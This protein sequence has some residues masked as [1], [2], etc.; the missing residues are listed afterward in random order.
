MRHMISA[1]L[2]IF[3]LLAPAAAVTGAPDVEADAVLL[4]ERETGT[5]LYEKNAHA[6]REPASV[7]KIMTMLLVMEAIEDG[8]LTKETMVP[9]SAHAAGMGGS[10]VYLKEGEQMSVHDML[11]AVAVASGNDAAVALGEAIAGSES[12]FVAM[13]NERAAELGMQETVFQNCTGLPAEGHVTSAYDIAVMSRE[14]LSHEDI[15]T[16]TT[17]WMD[18]LRGGTFQL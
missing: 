4:M 15:R 18:S 3:L 8:R 9:V 1:C 10:Q 17:I 2:A 5:I 14:L 6:V 13:M 7:T 16:Y 12:A 11:K